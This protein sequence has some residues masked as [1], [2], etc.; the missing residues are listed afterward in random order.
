MAVA[1]G[2]CDR[3]ANSSRFMNA[4]T[5]NNAGTNTAGLRRLDHLVDSA[6]SRIDTID[7]PMS[8]IGSALTLRDVRKRASRVALP[9]TNSAVTA[10]AHHI[11]MTVDRGLQ[12]MFFS[13]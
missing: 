10:A 8:I 2:A 12:G 3:K 5:T 6:T 1:D 9:P 7:V 4:L 11:A 13:G